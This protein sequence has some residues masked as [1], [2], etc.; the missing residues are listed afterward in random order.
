MVLESRRR[1]IPM[2]MMTTTTTKNA[3]YSP[4]PHVRFTPESCRG[5]RWPACPL[6]ANSCLVH[7]S[8]IGR[9]F[10]GETHSCAAKRSEFR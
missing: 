7:R 1:L 9:F 5:F 6:W 3:V 4:R 10:K 2:M 8:N